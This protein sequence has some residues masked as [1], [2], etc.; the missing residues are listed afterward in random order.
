MSE[1]TASGTGQRSIGGWLSALGSD[2]PTPGGGA[3]AAVSA[4]AGASLISMVAALTIGRDGFEAQ[5]ERMREILRRADDAREAF[6]QMADQDAAAFEAVMRAFRLPK[7]D[8]DQRSARTRAVQAAFV[9]AARVPME[10]AE[11]SVDLMVL[12]REA[13]AHGNANAASDGYS[14]A[15]ALYAAALCGVANVRINAAGL[16]DEAAR[17]ELTD[18]VERLREAATEQ[19][20]ET[21]SAFGVRVRT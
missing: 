11:R 3:F 15:V 7:D 4:A 8:D 19:L 1:H 9:G 17:R 12:A 16:K 14:G 10:V 2:E 5:E 6:L 13:T 21:A 20:R 18:R